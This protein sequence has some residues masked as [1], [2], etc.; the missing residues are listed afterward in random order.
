[1]KFEADSGSSTDFEVR[2]EESNTNKLNIDFNDYLNPSIN[3]SDDV[4]LDDTYIKAD[5]AESVTLTA[6]DR[7][8]LDRY[9]GSKEGVD[10][11]TAG[12]DVTMANHIK[13]GGGDDVIR[14]GANASLK[15]IDGG[16]G[17][18]TLYTQT[19][20]DDLK[21]KSI[22]E[23]NVVC[24]AAG[25]LIATLSGPVAIEALRAGDMVTTLDH[26]EQPIRWDRIARS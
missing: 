15:E 22:E 4:S 23:I 1:M 26:D 17:F 5:K 8:T 6:G 16:K 10:T 11:F 7:V 21:L 25:T 24:F 19:D 12:D 13:T 9:H 3:I 20:P 2:F 14:I 18:D